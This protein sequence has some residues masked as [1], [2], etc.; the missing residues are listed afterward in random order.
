MF[1][2]RTRVLEVTNLNYPHFGVW[3]RY[4][5]VSELMVVALGLDGP[6]DSK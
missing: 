5:L 1:R 2:G 3:G 6:G 4:R